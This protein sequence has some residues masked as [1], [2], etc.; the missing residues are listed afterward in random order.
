MCRH[1]QITHIAHV[2]LAFEP[3]AKRENFEIVCAA[4]AIAANGTASLLEQWICSVRAVF[5][6][7]FSVFFSLFSLWFWEWRNCLWVLAY[8][9]KCRKKPRQRYCSCIAVAATAHKIAFAFGFSHSLSRFYFSPFIRTLFC[10]V[11]NWDDGAKH[12]SM[13]TWNDFA[14]A[15]HLV[16]R[17]RLIHAY[18]AH[19][20]IFRTRN[21]WKWTVTM[22]ECWT[23]ERRSQNKTKNQ[24]NTVLLLVQCGNVLALT[25]T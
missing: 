22:D 10:F 4:A 20:H 24:K 5:G 2:Q 23:E 9:R 11:L 21:R 15:M 13:C 17:R 19:N 3:T 18:T 7:V 16:L 6:H 1:N 14:L 25:H 8:E 12:A